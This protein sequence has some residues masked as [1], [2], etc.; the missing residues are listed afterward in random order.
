MN[1]NDRHLLQ[2]LLVTRIQV[3]PSPFQFDEIQK[4][5]ISEAEYCEIDNDLDNDEIVI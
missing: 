1:R 2:E 3:D 4:R 5:L